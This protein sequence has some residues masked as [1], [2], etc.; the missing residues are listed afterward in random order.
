MMRCLADGGDDYITKPFHPEELLARVEAAMRRRSMSPMNNRMG[1][2]EGQPTGNAEEEKLRAFAA[3][4][5]LTEKEREALSCILRQQSLSDMAE[6]MRISDK[7]VEFHITH[8]L[9]KTG[10][11]RRRDVLQAYVNWKLSF[12]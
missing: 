5:N 10:I 7:G 4:H 3:H 2:K 11:K 12:F 8:I 6:S 9:Q 1:K